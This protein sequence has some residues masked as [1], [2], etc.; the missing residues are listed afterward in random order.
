MKWLFI[1]DWRTSL[2]LDS[3]FLRLC[4]RNDRHIG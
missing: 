4:A 2:T 1:P 3:I